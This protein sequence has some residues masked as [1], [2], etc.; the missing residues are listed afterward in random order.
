MQHN[1]FRHAAHEAVQTGKLPASGAP[2]RRIAALA[3]LCASLV[4]AACASLGGSS[5]QDRVQERASQRWQALV[6]GDFTKAYDF[7]TPAFRAVVNRDSF[8]GRFTTSVK[9]EGAEVVSVKCAEPTRC[10]ANVRIDFKPLLGSGFGD[11]INTH[12]DETWLLEDG[13]WWVF[14]SIKGN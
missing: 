10:T 14:Q 5:P 7:S 9:W 13:Q 11:K 1:M 12:I 3:P 6:T 4:L 2:W 8:R